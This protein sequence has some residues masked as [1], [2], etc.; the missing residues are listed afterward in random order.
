MKS[1]EKVLKSY[2]KLSKVIKSYQKVIKTHLNDAR[3]SGNDRYRKVCSLKR[4][5]PKG[6]LNPM[7]NKVDMIFEWNQKGFR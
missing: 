3:H 1:Y 7:A 6:I 2:E 4:Q 5:V